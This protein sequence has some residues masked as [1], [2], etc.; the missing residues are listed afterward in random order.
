M[1]SASATDKTTARILDAAL[2]EFS[3]YG[4]RR[5]GMEDVAKR[6][7]VARATVYR[8]FAVKEA[9]VQAVVLR[10]SRR[11]MDEFDAVVSKYGTLDEQVVEGWVFTLAYMSDHP[12]FNGLLRADPEAMLPYLTIGNEELLAASRDFLLPFLTAAQER[13]EMP[14]IDPRP[15]AELMARIVLSY[16]ISPAGCLDLADERRTREFA[17]RHLVPAVRSRA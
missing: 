17:R 6:A 12:L 8:K 11:Y 2:A 16:V 10:E 1:T 14:D 7:G 5:T 13:G 15:V 3:A 9:L 4:L